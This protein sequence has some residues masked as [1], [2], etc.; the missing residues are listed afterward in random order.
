[1]KGEEK[2]FT[3]P[4]ELMKYLKTSED[5]EYMWSDSEDFAILA[6]MYQINIKIITIDGRGGKPSFNWVYP[7]AKMAKYAELKN[8]DLEDMV[9]LHE[10]DTHFNLV[11]HGESD[12]ATQ[13]SLSYR[14]NI[15]PMT[16]MKNVVENESDAV[17]DLE[18]EEDN[19]EQIKKQLKKI[20]E[21]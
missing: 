12:L 7:H 9:L 8:V 13:G 20:K 11:V 14:F 3:D 10:K 19:V 1:V 15:G 5:A 21:N 6:D 16:T 4:I 18:D 17:I 2:S